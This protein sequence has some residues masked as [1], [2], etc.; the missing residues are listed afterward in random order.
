[1]PRQENI[2]TIKMPVNDG[3][4]EGK[5]RPKEEF[6][7]T[8]SIVYALTR[9]S[10]VSF[11]TEGNSMDGLVAVLPAD[12][13]KMSFDDFK[14]AARAAGANP[15]LWLKAKHAGLLVTEVEADGS[16]TIRRNEGEGE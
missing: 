11:G 2:S 14:A 9:T 13:S 7:R 12:G 3:M 5:D 10:K 16:L 1:M 6:D 15:Q 8:L 4:R